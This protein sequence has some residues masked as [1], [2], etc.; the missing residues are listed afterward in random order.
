VSPAG[1]G[2]GADPGRVALG[3]SAHTGWTAAVALELDAGAPVVLERRRLELIDGSV[4][5][6]VYHAASAMGLEEAA[7]QHGLGVHVVPARELVPVAEAILGQDA[8]TL[9]QTLAA[10]GSA[11]GPPWRKDQ[12]DATLAA[13]V[14]VAQHRPRRER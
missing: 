14:A 1:A 8:A 13:W 4:P 12:K 10:L 2:A 3:F 5:W 6:Q 7:D 9:R 11:L